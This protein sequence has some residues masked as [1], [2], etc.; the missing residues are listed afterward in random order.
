MA[1]PVSSTN[2]G[3]GNSYAG[4]VKALSSFGKARDCRLHGAGMATKEQKLG[5]DPKPG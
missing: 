4:I 5:Q 2:R 3:E 1:L